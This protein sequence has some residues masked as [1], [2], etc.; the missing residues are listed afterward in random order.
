[1]LAL[2]STSRKQTQPVVTSG[3]F[4][5]ELSLAMGLSL[6]HFDLGKYIFDNKEESEQLE[7]LL[8]K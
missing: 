3:A 5:R 6:S 2:T 4:L 7:Q 8:L 1:V